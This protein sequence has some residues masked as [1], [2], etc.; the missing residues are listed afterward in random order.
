MEGGGVGWATEPSEMVLG[1]GSWETSRQ[2]RKKKHTT[3]LSL[4]SYGGE[5]PLGHWSPETVFLFPRK[6]LLHGYARL[7]LAF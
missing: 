4:S 2:P 1:I 5:K 3:G 7:P 6:E